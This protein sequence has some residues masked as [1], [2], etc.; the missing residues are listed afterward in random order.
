MLVSSNKL[1]SFGKPS[2]Q[3]KETFVECKHLLSIERY[4]RVK[5]ED[6]FESRIEVH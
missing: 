5:A 1:L 6:K 2:R 4:G 3:F